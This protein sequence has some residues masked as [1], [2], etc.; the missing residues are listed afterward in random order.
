MQQKRR[1]LRK[2]Y[3]ARVSGSE[4]NVPDDIREVAP[5]TAKH[6]RMVKHIKKSYGKKGGLTDEEKSIAYA[7]AWKDYKKE[8][9]EKV[10]EVL[11]YAAR[12]AS[13]VVGAAVQGMSNPDIKPNAAKMAQKPKSSSSSSSKQGGLSAAQSQAEK[14]KKARLDARKKAIE[15][16]KKDRRERAQDIMTTDKALKKKK[17]ESDPTKAPAAPNAKPIVAEFVDN[18][19]EAKKCP[20][21]GKKPH[22]GDCKPC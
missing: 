6:E 18:L 13:G 11:G 7:T 8:E 21:C 9:F 2:E 3:A 17:S 22:K 20:E 10:N 12:I 5:P 15:K 1:R 4:D 14:A 16:I 19:W